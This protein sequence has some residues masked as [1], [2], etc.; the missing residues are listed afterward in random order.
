MPN[1]FSNQKLNEAKAKTAQALKGDIL[2]EAKTTPVRASSVT[3]AMLSE[4]L[5]KS[6]NRK[7]ELE[8]HRDAISLEIED[9]DQ[10]I[11]AMEA[12]ISVIDGNLPSTSSERQPI[13]MAS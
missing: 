8:G 5:F 12:G 10:V 2:T 1:Q 6:Q 13:E 3:R 11:R 7:M 4:R 9:E